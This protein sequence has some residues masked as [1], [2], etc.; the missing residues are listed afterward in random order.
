MAESRLHCELDG[1]FVTGGGNPVVSSI[2]CEAFA[3]SSALIPGKPFSSPE[4]ELVTLRGRMRSS[5]VLS[6]QRVRR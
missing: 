2:A 4:C 3:R 1:P 6:P 5:K